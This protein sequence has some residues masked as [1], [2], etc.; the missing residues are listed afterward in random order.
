[1]TSLMKM[2]DNQLTENFLNRTFFEAWKPENKDNIL[3]GNYQALELQINAACDLKCKYCYYAKYKN[4]LY[5]P[6]IAKH[7]VTLKNL[8]MVLNW[9]TE[10]NYH[11]NIEIFSGEP[12]MQEIGF[13]VTE[14]IAE[15]RKEN[16]VK[17]N[18]MVPTN[19][20]FLFDDERT[21]R[22]EDMIEKADGELCL[23][24]SVDG[25]YCDANRPF[26]NGKTFRDDAYYDKLFAFVAKHRYAFHPMI[27]GENIEHWKDNWLWFQENMKKHDI[28]FTAIYLLEVRNVEWTRQQLKEFYKFIRFVVNWSWNHV[29]DNVSPNNFPRFV[30]D[31]KL[32]NLFSMFGTVGR[33]LGCSMESTVQLRLGDLTTSVC[34]RAAYKP[35]NLWKF[36]TSN[37]KIVGVETLNPNLLLACN[38]FDFRSAPYCTYCS[39]RDLCNGQCLG[40]M[41]E[42]HADLFT[43]IPTVCAL[44]HMKVAAMLDELKELDL[45]QHFYNLVNMDK[46][47]SLKV[48]DQIFSKEGEQNEI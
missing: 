16:N 6:S 22:V 25:K 28:P 5:N 7:S 21:K 12:Y 48:Y 46:K 19:F 23:S 38:S 30:F 27:Y 13:K 41:Y 35:H 10:N 32:F 20:T 47:K 44:E 17:T 18:F 39:I 9:L 36:V 3:Y 29:K 1:M 37:D 42:T 8:D 2:E 24:A 43:P 15:W 11:P 14:R 40:A 31:H 45:F 33:G 34:H 26:S 4:E